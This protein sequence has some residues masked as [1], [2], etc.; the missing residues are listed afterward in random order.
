[1]HAHDSIDVYLTIRVFQ[2]PLSLHFL[3]VSDLL[4]PPMLYDP[5]Y[6]DSTYETMSNHA[7]HTNF[8]NLTLVSSLPHPAFFPQ[9]LVL[10]GETT[11]SGSV[12]GTPCYTLLIQRQVQFSSV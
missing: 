7:S 1:M 10:E 3:S 2:I 11:V 9:S 4:D 6:S 5:H 8:Q 12:G